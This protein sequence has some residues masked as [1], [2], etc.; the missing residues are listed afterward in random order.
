MVDGGG[1]GGVV[2]VEWKKLVIGEEAGIDTVV[3]FN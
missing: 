2:A 1:G 3:L